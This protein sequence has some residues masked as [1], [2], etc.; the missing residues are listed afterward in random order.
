[1]LAGAI[2]EFFRRGKQYPDK[3]CYSS[4]GIFWLHFKYNSNGDISL[5]SFRSLLHESPTFLCN[6]FGYMQGI[7]ARLIEH[8]IR[9]PESFG[10]YQLLEWKVEPPYRR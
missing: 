7:I 1:M 3:M 10:S 9:L 6:N 8:R 5:G 2:I 4:S